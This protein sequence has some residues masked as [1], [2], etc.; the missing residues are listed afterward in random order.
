MCRIISVVFRHARPPALTPSSSSGSMTSFCCTLVTGELFLLT[1]RCLSLSVSLEF[2]CRVDCV[3]SSDSLMKVASEFSVI[4]E[5]IA[6]VSGSDQ[7]NE[8]Q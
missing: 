4:D 8:V 1:I 5:L 7:D 6:D 2:A 3:D